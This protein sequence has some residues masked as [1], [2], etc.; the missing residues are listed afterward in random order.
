MPLQPLL[1]LNEVM[2]DDN[3][4]IEQ[5][6]NNQ[7]PCKKP[8]KSDSP[9]ED[10]PVKIVKKHSAIELFLIVA[11]HSATPKVIIVKDFDGY[12]KDLVCLLI[13]S[14]HKKKM[15]FKH[16]QIIV[17]A[18]PWRSYDLVT[19]EKEDSLYLDFY[20]VCRFAGPTQEVKD[21]ILRLL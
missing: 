20:S 16:K 3:Q 21:E 19:V 11:N 9:T 10:V 12:F 6:P 5:D 2:S 15:A 8:R 7:G 14:K 17:S 4:R 18:G 13:E 1:T